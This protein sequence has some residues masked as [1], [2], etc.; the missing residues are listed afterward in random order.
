MERMPRTGMSAAGESLLDMIALVM[1][2]SS[3]RRFEI[4]AGATGGMVDVRRLWV[5][6]DEAALAA[7]R[8]DHLGYVLQTGGLLPFLSVRDNIG[9][10]GRMAMFQATPA[11]AS[12]R[13][14]APR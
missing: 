1:M 10:P 3:V 5:Q 2:P 13:L 8:R 6:G 9:L 7:L 12:G 14:S 11:L 4:D